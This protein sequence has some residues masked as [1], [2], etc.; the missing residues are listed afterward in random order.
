MQMGIWSSQHT[1]DGK[2]MVIIKRHKLDQ[3]NAQVT[4]TL[5]RERQ[6]NFC[7][8]WR[9]CPAQDACFMSTHFVL[10]IDSRHCKDLQ[11]GFKS[12]LYVELTLQRWQQP[13]EPEHCTQRIEKQKI[14]KW[15][16]PENLDHVHR[17]QFKWR[18]H[19]CLAIG[20]KRG[21]AWNSFA[22]WL[23]KWDGTE[24]HASTGEKKARFCIQGWVWLNSKWSKSTT[25]VSE[26]WLVWQS[27][28]EIFGND[29]VTHCKY[30]N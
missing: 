9:V 14:L 25:Y 7:W 6:W 27:I 20:F 10:N 13:T 24:R 2:Q 16:G 29:I 11:V 17:R 22:I 3:K 19:K 26:H 1:W 15:E 28:K 12:G 8:I 21:W 30:R 18:H 4:G 23:G 5:P